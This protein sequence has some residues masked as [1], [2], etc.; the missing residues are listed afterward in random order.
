MQSSKYFC[1]QLHITGGAFS[2]FEQFLGNFLVFL[3]QRFT[4]FAAHSVEA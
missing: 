4:I 3:E 1:E 2:I